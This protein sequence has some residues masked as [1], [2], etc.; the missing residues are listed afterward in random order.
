MS[1]DLQNVHRR[2][3]RLIERWPDLTAEKLSANELMWLGEAQAL[4]E[5]SGDTRAISEFEAAMLNINNSFIDF[6]TNSRARIQMA[7]FRAF[8]ALEI[9]LPIGE[10]G[11]F[12][13]AGNVLDAYANISKILASAAKDV[14]IVDPYMDASV[15]TEYGESTNPQSTLRLL[16]DPATSRPNLASAAQRWASQYGANRPLS[17]RLAGPR[18]LHD[19][20]IFIDGKSAWTLTQSLKDFAKRSPAEI[21]RVND[22]ADLKIAAYEAIWGTA[23]VVV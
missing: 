20:A 15:I 6:R 3:A 12:V 16:T 21:I 22:I 11:A 18:Q 17:V 9:K 10:Q 4:L 13:P 7:I 23:S 8:T 1:N 5:A 19:R 14:F 2:L